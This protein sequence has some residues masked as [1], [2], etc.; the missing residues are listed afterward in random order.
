[1]SII[2]GKKN[3]ES[4]LKDFNETN[5]KMNNPEYRKRVEARLQECE[6]LWRHFSAKGNGSSYKFFSNKGCQFYPCHDLKEI[7][8]LFC[9][10]PLYRKKYRPECKDTPCEEC[11]FP[12]KRENYEKIIEFLNI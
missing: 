11:V 2:K 10:C 6:K 7:N 4:F 9:F 5:E 3:I 1:M 12:H 8:C